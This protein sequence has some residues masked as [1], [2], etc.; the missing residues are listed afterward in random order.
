MKEK[1]VMFTT[2]EG[3]YYCTDPQLIDKYRK[4]RKYEDTQCVLQGLALLGWLIP[5]LTIYIATEFFNIWT[6]IF[7]CILPT[8]LY[9]IPF[10]WNWVCL[11]KMDKYSS[12]KDEFYESKEYKRQYNAYK[13]KEKKRIDKLKEEGARNLIDVWNLLNDDMP[14]EIKIGY[15]KE[16]M[17]VNTN[18]IQEDI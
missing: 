2:R 17:G 12:Y 1:I 14:D 10:T 15:L 18:D 3:K 16:Y 9:L 13:R 7:L 11:S 8:A 4:Y 6:L 5:A